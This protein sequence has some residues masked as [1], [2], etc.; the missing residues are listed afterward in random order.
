[1]PLRCRGS[2]CGGVGSRGFREHSQQK[3]GSTIGAFIITHIKFYFLFYLFIF[4]FIFILSFFF[5]GGVLIAIVWYT[6]QNPIL[7]IA[8]PALAK[9]ARRLAAAQGL[10]MASG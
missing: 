9:S 4:I 7:T 2:R 3:N 1:M 10:G 5:G 6:P 8:A